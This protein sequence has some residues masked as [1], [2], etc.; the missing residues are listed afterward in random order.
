MPWKYVDGWMVIDIYYSHT[1]S[2]TA[3]ALFKHSAPPSVHRV[4][5]TT[6]NLI[7]FVGNIEH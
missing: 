2:V 6:E 7:N 5:A 4:R 3:P 1:V